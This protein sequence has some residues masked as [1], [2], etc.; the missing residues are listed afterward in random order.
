MILYGASGHAKVIISCLQAGGL[1]VTAV[2]DDDL[3]KTEISGIKVIGPYQSRAHASEPLIIAIGDNQ[4]RRRI[5]AGITHTFG[6]AVHP[7]ALV[8]KTVIIGEGT[9]IM[10]RAVVQADTSLGKHVIIN[11]TASIDHDC[12]IGD[13]VHIAPGVVLC[14]NVQVG[15]NTLIGVGSAVVP[16]ITIGKN[17]LLTA[18]CVVT[19]NVPD[20]SVVRG[21]PAR[22]V[23]NL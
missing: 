15:E 12:R 23:S 14:G 9:V 1:S 2:F 6:I 19:Q 22:I 3:S 7:S 13:F 18:G 10:H 11:T 5:A 8:D 21:N 4:I 20:G 16:N 17:C